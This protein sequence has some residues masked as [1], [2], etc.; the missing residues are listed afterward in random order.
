MVSLSLLVL[1]GTGVKSLAA[2]LNAALRKHSCRLSAVIPHPYTLTLFTTVDRY[3]VV[4]S[5]Y[6]WCIP[7]RASSLSSKRNTSLFFPFAAK[8]F[9][10]LL[11]LSS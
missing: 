11:S 5:L 3:V 2:N 9:N 6:R 7:G 4:S 1:P 8:I 10:S